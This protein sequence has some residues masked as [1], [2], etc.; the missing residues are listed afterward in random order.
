MVKS[1]YPAG[2][3]P[4]LDGQAFQGEAQ[5]GPGWTVE[6]GLGGWGRCLPSA[7]EQADARGERAHRAHLPGREATGT[8]AFVGGD[9]ELARLANLHA[10]ATLVP[11][12]DDA[13][14]ASL[15]VRSKVVRWAW[16]G[17][18]GHATREHLR[19]VK[20]DCPGSFVHQNW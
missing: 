17:A 11:A 7:Q 4:S 10:K 9:H 1:R 13:T 20:G 8:V 3:A 2:R 12:F 6:F 14:D 18:A 15:C 19:Y 16:G 5:G